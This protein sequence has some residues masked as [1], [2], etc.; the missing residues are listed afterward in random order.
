MDYKPAIEVIDLTK[1]YKLPNIGA[2]LE[3]NTRAIELGSSVGA[4]SNYCYENEAHNLNPRS[5]LGFD[6]LDP[7]GVLKS[8]QNLD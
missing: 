6:S 3:S 7:N 5:H 8:S 1:P 4:K 2:N